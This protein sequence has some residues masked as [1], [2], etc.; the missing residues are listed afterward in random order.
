MKQ[1]KRIAR[2]NI[3]LLSFILLAISCDSFHKYSDGIIVTTK[4]GV[5]NIEVI[6][7]SLVHVTKEPAKGSYLTNNLIVKKIPEPCTW[8]TKTRE[9][10][11]EL[12]TEKIK[13]RIDNCGTIQFFD[14]TGKIL[15]CEIPEDQFTGSVNHSK[16]AV[17][18][19]F[20]CGDEGLFGLGQFQD[21]MM[22]WKNVPLR[23]KQ[24]NQII[25]IPFLISTNNYG[26]LWNNYSITDFNP[27]LLEIKFESTSDNDSSIRNGKFTP[28]ISGIH[29]FF[30]DNPNPDKNRFRGP[31][32]LT[33]N[34]D[35]VIH[36]STIW[37]PDC[38]T[39]RIY[40]EAGE[41][42]NIIFQNLNA[43][44]AG[45]IYVNPPDY[46]KTVFCSYGGKATDYY[47]VYGENPEM[48]ISNYHDLTGLAPMFPLS[49]FGF[50]QCRERYHSQQEL[51]ENAYEYRRREIP[52]DNIVQD[53]NYWPEKTWGPQWNRVFYE[54]PANMCDS[55]HQM[56]MN[57]MVSVW[58][59]IENQRL[60]EVYHLNE[61]KYPSSD[62]L[63]FFDPVVRSNY[64]QMLRDSM[65]EFGV[66][67]IWLDGTEP[68]EY[69]HKADCYLG[70]FDDY[71][72]AYSLM[73]SQ[74]VYE[75]KR[76]D[77]PD[78]RVFNLTRSAFAGQQAYAAA[79]WS[80][81][82][83][84]TWEQYAEQIPAGLNFSMSGL[85]YWTT[86]I[87]GFFRDSISLNATYDDQYSN[88]EYIELL[89]RW[90]QFGTF[91]PIFRIHGYQ[92]NTEIWRYGERFEEVAR[93]YIDLRYRLL[94]YIYSEARHISKSGSIMMRPLAMDY[95]AD[96]TT[97][98]IADQFLFGRSI[99]VCPV[100][101]FGARQR[102][103]YFPE[104]TW[105]NFYTEDKIEGG[106]ILTVRAPLEE[107]PVYIRSGSIIPFGPIVQYTGEKTE[108][109]LEIMIYPGNDAT[110]VLYEDDY[111]TYD[112]EKGIY[113]EILFNYL[114]TGKKLIISDDP[115]SF[116]DYNSNL[117]RFVIHIIGS[118]EK[119]QILYQGKEQI[120]MFDK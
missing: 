61:N 16:Y 91:C 65:F 114:E 85:P 13:L 78:Q 100:T 106:D 109:P 120:Y 113:S 68:E 103:I 54:D 56:N 40:L 71:A 10:V 15:L 35:T 70:K 98:E 60:E 80:G 45:K 87:G 72:N 116:Y 92:S 95:P 84:G 34:S 112:Y 77:Y 90:F 108:D 101:R 22:N 1:F 75:G 74:S 102:K 89:T 33:I 19:E 28:E 52:V 86:D 59:R 110:F 53:W 17:V 82:V 117:K 24:F 27:P 119:I 39:G 47:F 18:Q 96:R 2:I 79:S 44:T 115:G 3:V 14:N 11:I 94:P 99:M 9:G 26:L 43:N 46:N 69:P 38:L 55:L 104:G 42:Y 118:D 37:V 73:V 93:K 66:N 21:G 57:L 12:S 105:Y 67:S 88:A 107:I 32:L 36:Y 4:K 29:H 58:P 30:M 7:E 23:L 111:T 83:A 8:T 51:L 31:V 97:W 76:K 20:T 62:Y 6:S 50:W 64:Y 63:D 25:A 49:A 81:D 48:I 41:E 5:I